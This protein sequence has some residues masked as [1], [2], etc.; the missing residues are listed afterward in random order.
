MLIAG[1]DEVGRGAWAGPLCIV[2]VVLQDGLLTGLRDSKHFSAQK[3]SN[4]FSQIQ[5]SA[6]AISIF[7]ANNE[8]IDNKGL[9]SC[10]RQGFNYCSNQLT[11]DVFILDG[12]VNYL[13][14]DRVVVQPKA[15]DTYP[16]V[17]AASIIAKQL[18]DA[19]MKQLGELDSRYG[20]AQHVGYGTSL[21]K[22]SIKQYGPS[23]AHR[24][25]FKGV[26]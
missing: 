11:A 16:A 8:L 7:W 24:L 22:N 20:F 23:T 17:A 18:R 1:F 3:R 6:H 25:S 12:N 5:R 9:G 19:Y 14:R 10:I 4:L 15:D 21:H 2:G 13:N 26:L